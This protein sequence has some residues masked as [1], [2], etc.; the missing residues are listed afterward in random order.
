MRHA[1]EE[2]ENIHTRLGL[3]FLGIHAVGLLVVF[4]SKTNAQLECCD[5]PVRS[6]HTVR[7]FTYPG[8][9]SPIAAEHT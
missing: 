5:L 3:V 1:Q 7:L 6:P 9:V 2:Q 4:Q 8:L